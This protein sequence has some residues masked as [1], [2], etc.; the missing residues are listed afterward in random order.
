[1]T[2]TTNS[3]ND[4]NNSNTS[5]TAPTPSD[6]TS[7][8]DP[9]EQSA[10]GQIL[11]AARALDPK[12]LLPLNLDVPTVVTTCVAVA[13]RVL[14]YRGFIVGLGGYDI[15]ALDGLETVALALA[16]AHGDY[17]FATSPHDALNDL[18]DRA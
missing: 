4:S 1:M 11:P 5:T 8:T 12:D 6:L 16:V 14:A 7:A 2:T 3:T 15:S 18:V 17:V 13:K 9:R 10:Y